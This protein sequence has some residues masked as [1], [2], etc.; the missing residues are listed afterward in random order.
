MS[1]SFNS[2]LLRCLQFSSC[3]SCFLSVYCL[4]IWS[5]SVTVCCM[6]KGLWE[7]VCC[8]YWCVPYL[9]SFQPFREFRV[10]CLPMSIGPR[11]SEC[12]QDVHPSAHILFILHILLLTFYLSW[13]T[14]GSFG[15]QCTP[16]CLEGE[17]SSVR[18][19][20]RFLIFLC[21]YFFCLFYLG[22]SLKHR[23]RAF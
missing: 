6:T 4:F 21:H 18:S 15:T 20:M 7:F 17:S 5:L 1:L 12:P 16:G 19:F 22:I 11:R 2:F 23:P 3:V 8:M 9:F 14:I 10:Q 13:P